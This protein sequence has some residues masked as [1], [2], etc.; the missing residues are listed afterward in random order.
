MGDT[1]LHSTRLFF[2]GKSLI[3]VKSSHWEIYDTGKHNGSAR[4]ERIGKE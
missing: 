3:K 1:I 4:R 2:A